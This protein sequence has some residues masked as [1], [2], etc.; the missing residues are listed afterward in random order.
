MN[1]YVKLLLLFSISVS[2]VI[3]NMSIKGKCIFTTFVL[4]ISK[5]N[6]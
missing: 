6:T 1:E 2:L 4:L 5:Q 3:N